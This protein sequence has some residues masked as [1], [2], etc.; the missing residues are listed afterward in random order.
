MNSNGGLDEHFIKGTVV[1]FSAEAQNVLGSSVPKHTT[2]ATL[3]L[4]T[5]LTV[6]VAQSEGLLTGDELDI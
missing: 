4:L 6:F 2:R 1:N 3:T 5:K